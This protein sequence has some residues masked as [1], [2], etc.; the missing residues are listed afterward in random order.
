MRTTHVLAAVA[1]A[2][3]AALPA[4]PAAAAG[5]E[6]TSSAFAVAASMET[7]AERTVR[8]VFNDVLDREPTDRELRRYRDLME[9]S[10]WS[11]ADVRNDLRRDSS[12]RR[13]RR[14]SDRMTR[15]EAE[16]I[17]RRA[18]RDVLN[19]EPDR[20]GRGYVDKVLNDNWT[21]EDVE[22]DLRKS[23]EY[24]EVT[25][26]RAE[27]IVRNAYRA[28]LGRDPDAGAQTYVTKVMRERWTQQQVERELRKSPEYRQRSR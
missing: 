8:R 18:Y 14:D 25:R 16:R 22:R 1:L 12:Y 7:R 27:E 15:R 28:V 21:A 17:V 10:G 4:A 24:R 2:L 3:P 5:H 26:E 23:S 20:G 11:E 9:D 19:R 6:G 13:D